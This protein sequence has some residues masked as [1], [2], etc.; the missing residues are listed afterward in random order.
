MRKTFLLACIPAAVLL[1]VSLVFPPEAKSQASQGNFTLL[2]PRVSVTGGTVTNTAAAV[3]TVN[4]ADLIMPSAT[5]TAVCVF[6][7]TAHTG[8]P[9]TTIAIQGKHTATS[10]Y[11]T[12]LI[13]G[14]VT[15]DNT[16]IRL[17]VGP[18]V[19]TT[20]NI[21]AGLPMPA[22]WRV[23]EVIGGSGTVTGVISCGAH[24]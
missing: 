11:Y 4:S 18:G 17:A 19:A 12:I 2:H 9:S 21:G 1:L 10:Q 15:A 3:G 6:T 23:Q 13:S 7:M 14:A 8:S 20:A 24:G 5:D 16:P 22:T